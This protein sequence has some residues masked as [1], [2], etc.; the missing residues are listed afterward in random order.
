MSKT[1]CRFCDITVEGI[2][3]NCPRCGKWLAPD[4]PKDPNLIQQPPKKFKLVQLGKSWNDQF[5]PIP[6][7]ENNGQ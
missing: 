5:N 1:Y 6:D 2:Y 3:L 7:K 4:P